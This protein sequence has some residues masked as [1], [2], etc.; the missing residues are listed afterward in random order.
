MW[1]SLITVVVINQ[2][3]KCKLACEIGT[4]ALI[5]EMAIGALGSST[6]GTVPAE[7]GARMGGGAELRFSLTPEPAWRMR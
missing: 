1:G 7:G 6:A 5:C 3:S 4:G 2:N